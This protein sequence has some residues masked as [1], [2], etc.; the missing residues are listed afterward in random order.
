MR[1]WTPREVLATHRALVANGAVAAHLATG[2]LRRLTGRDRPPICTHLGGVLCWND[3]EESWDCPLHGSRF[4][5]DGKVLEGP[6]TRDL[7]GG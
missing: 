4:G 2:H 5:T 6:A 1:S 7:E 3:S